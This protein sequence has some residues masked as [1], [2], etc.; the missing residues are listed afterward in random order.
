MSVSPQGIWDSAG[1][2]RGALVC[3]GRTEMGGEV[4]QVREILCV[5][6]VIWGLLVE[7]DQPYPSLHSPSVR[8]AQAGR[9]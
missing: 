9:T 2:Q 8:N 3:E 4:I 5:A 6:R 1:M 7:A